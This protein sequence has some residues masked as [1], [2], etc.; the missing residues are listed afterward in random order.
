MI[1]AQKRLISFSVIFWCLYLFSA[2]DIFLV[3]LEGFNCYQSAVL[4]FHVFDSG[5][6]LTVC[7]WC[8]RYQSSQPTHGLIIIPESQDLALCMYCDE[9]QMKVQLLED[10]ACDKHGQPSQTNR[11]NSKCLRV[12]CYSIYDVLAG[13]KY[14]IV[15]CSLF[16]WCFRIDI[17]IVQALVSCQT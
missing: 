15:L 17:I 16:I 14:F 13:C 7:V 5:V 11:K 4:W 9:H 3:G 10:H 1:C 12:R 6:C 2:R 8:L